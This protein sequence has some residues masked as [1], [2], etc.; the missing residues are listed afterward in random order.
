M[1]RNGKNAWA[2]IE[3]IGDNW[4]RFYDGARKLIQSEKGFYDLTHIFDEISGIYIDGIHC[5]EQG[6]RLL[7]EKHDSE[8]DFV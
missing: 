7:A 3:K 4:R 8:K 5:S 6:N 2:S 1:L